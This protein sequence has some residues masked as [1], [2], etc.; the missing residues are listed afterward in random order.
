METSIKHEHPVSWKALGRI[1]IVA[2]LVLLLW[3]A[4]WIFV[5]ILIA[6]VL[7]TALYPLVRVVHK[8]FRLLPSII[9]VLLGLV[10]PF[11]LIGYFVIPTLI[12]QLPDLLQAFYNVIS[13]T[14]FLP[15]SIRS[16]NLVGYANNHTA[17]ILAS[18][19]TIFYG[20]VTF[21]TI[22]FSMFY[23]ILDHIQLT[24]LFLS[25]FPTKQRGRISAL[26]NQLAQVNGQY[27][28]GNIIISFIC[29][30]VI[31]IGLILLGVPYALPL[32]I[33]AGILDLLPLVGST[34]GALP[35]V[36]IAFTISPLKGIL[37]LIL[38]LVY[39]Q[40]ENVVISPAIYNKALN[41]SP[42]LGFLTVVVGGG[43]FGIIGAFL[44]LPVAASIPVL[45]HFAHEY[46]EENST[47]KEKRD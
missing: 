37:V 1:V 12:K 22:F 43:L 38:H 4:V 47:E 21:F 39:Q 16:F 20:I 35:A 27:I 19:P 44:A 32:A 25:L 36:I 5:D 14:S 7:A 13:H 15:Q 8:K 40:T 10:I 18:S 45:L 23:L 34:I 26:L 11:A 30:A 31:F 46:G 3:K 2:L 24:K 42:A 28:R 17:D 9:L 41:L 29:G 6:L 33:C